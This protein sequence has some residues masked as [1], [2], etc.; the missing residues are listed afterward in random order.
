MVLVLACLC[1]STAVAATG[2]DSELIW[3]RIAKGMRLV[4]GEQPETVIW[5]RHYARNPIQF[6]QMLARSEPFLWY[7]VEA[8]ELR[9]L[10]LEIALV[11]AV[12]SSFDSQARSQRKARG[13]WQFIPR[14][15]RAL[16]LQ[17]TSHY[18]AKRDAVESTRAA[19]TYLLKLHRRFNQDW[20][21][22]LAAYNIGERTLA[23]AIERAG[24]PNFW[25]L[26]LPAETREHIPRLLG[27]A[28]L[29]QQPE[30]FNISLPPIYNRNAAEMVVLDKPRDLE[31]AARRADVARATIERYNP[32]L[33]TLANTQGKRW[34]LLPEE[35][36]RRLRAELAQRE[37]QPTAK[38]AQ[39]H[40]VSGGE[41]LW[42]IARRYKVSVAELREWNKLGKSS[43]LKPGR[44]LVIQQTG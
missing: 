38:V 35:E 36:A 8:V 41:S 43:A 19:L 5:A 42:R 17:E 40:I 25:D 10:P 22:T 14:T 21:L 16:G 27:I 11:P 18:D 15:G 6:A 7:I 29:I 32:G 12:E 13:L 37:Y 3:P 31:K 28:L 34:L 24:S 23:E 20:L 39:E 33:K 4:D 9:E 2:T 26:D 30:R 1:G 44:R